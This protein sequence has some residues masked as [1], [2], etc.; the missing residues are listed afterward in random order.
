VKWLI[1]IYP[2]NLAF[3]VFDDE[4][5]AR[6]I[7]VNGLF[8]T[9]ASLG[10]REQE[11]LR[12]RFDERLTLEQ[13]GKRLDIT[14]ERIRQVEAKAIRK[15]RHP[16]R[17][18]EFS[19]VPM[20]ALAEKQADYDRLAIEYDRLAKAFEL[21]TGKEASRNTVETMAKAVD[22]YNI[23]VDALG[24]SVRTYN[25]LRRA[26]KDTLGDI[27]EMTES[28]LCKVRNLGAKSR[29]EVVDVLA[30]YGLTLKYARSEVGKNDQRR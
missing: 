20:T 27:A 18:R 5:K 4:Y 2:F 24:L 9:L 13:C 29:K 14:R 21:V 25:A 17:V 22:A 16:S 12:M 19:S 8:R 15:L 6:D 11:V 10:E 7:S 28:Q 3:R 23:P 1:D 26:G 30:S